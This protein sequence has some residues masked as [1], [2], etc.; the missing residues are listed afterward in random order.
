MRRRVTTKID[1]DLCIG[2]GECVRVCP[3]WTIEMHDDKAVV[4]G[5]YSIGCG[6]CLAVCPAGAVSV[7]Y[8]DDDA[9]W[10]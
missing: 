4:T 8:V 10:L 3:S 1:Q 7:G 9:L 5:E 2:C 6:H